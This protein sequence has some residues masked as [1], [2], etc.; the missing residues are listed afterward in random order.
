MSIVLTV[1]KI[2]GIILGILLAVILGLLLLIL[3]LP[4]CYHVRGNLEPESNE[5]FG[6]I[7]WFFSIIQVKM[8][9]KG[10]DIRV[11]LSILGWKKQ[12]YPAKEGEEEEHP[13]KRGNKRKKAKEESDT[14]EDEVSIQATELPLETESQ[15]EEPKPDSKEQAKTVNLSKEDD[16]IPKADQVTGKSKEKSLQKY[17]PWN[18][19]KSWIGKIR[20]LA[21]RLKENFANIKR[22]LS[23]E[24]NKNAI[25]HIWREL[26]SLLRHI[27]PRRGRVNLR[28]S[29]GD[30]ATT[31][32]LTGMFSLCPLFYKKGI[33]VIPNFTADKFY[34][35]GRFQIHGHIQMF[36]FLG[37]A[38]RLYRD[39][40]IKKLIQK[41]K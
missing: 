19:M 12:F 25:G 8:E 23:D 36:H 39:K 27:G 32:Q 18:I 13:K 34:I 40:N 31:G 35:R 26:K 41:F 9:A 20:K 6:R 3:F 17:L 30:P 5:V 4:I 37:I 33:A 10:K 21:H 16:K 28:Y 38:W 22:E 2:I 1:L 29:T 14:G 11:W 7:S 24:T 15:A